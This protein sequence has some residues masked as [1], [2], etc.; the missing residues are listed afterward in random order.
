MY[1]VCIVGGGVIGCAIARELARC[2]L[3]IALL[4]KH[5]DVAEGTSKAN[6]AIV[7]AGYDARPGTVKARTNIAGNAV[8]EAWCRE[9]DVPFRRNTSLVVTFNTE[10]IFGLREL[11][12]R[13]RKNGVPGLHLLSQTELRA[14]EPN[15]GPSACGALLAET[16]GICCPYELTIALAAQAVQNGVD[17]KLNCQVTSVRKN[18]AG[19]FLLQTSQGPLNCRTLVNAAGVHADGINNQLSE[20][21]FRIIP[22]RGEYWMVDKAFGSAF[23]ATIFQLPTAMGKGILVTPT[24][25]GTVILG[26]TAEDIDNKEDTRTTAAKLE[27]ILRVASLSWA[28][29]PRKNFITAFAGVRA[30]PEHNDFILG[31]APDVPG[32][33]NAAGVESPGL[34]AAPAIAGELAGLVAARLGAR[35]KAEYQPPWPAPKHF[36][37]MSDSER[38]AAIAENPEYGR[39]ICRCEQISEAEIRAAIRRPVGATTLDGVKRRTRAGM[40]RCQG[41]FCTPRV[42]HILSEELDVSPLELTKSGGLSKILTGRVGESEAD[43]GITQNGGSSHG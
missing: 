25:E 16:G 37:S 20:N 11:L 24:V 38:Q 13:G 27:E 2:E 29:I 14:R 39:I 36:R 41:G 9:L 35:N 22:R 23:S 32:L 1:D 18:P 7:H 31:E 4:E 19:G 43:I 34:T 17:L 12:E 26:P 15:I 42:L 3:S 6:S 21:R 8:F 33:F 30:H 28:Q 40:G 5:S 10:G